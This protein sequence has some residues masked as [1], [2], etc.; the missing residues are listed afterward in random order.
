MPTLFRLSVYKKHT[1]NGGDDSIE[2]TLQHAQTVTEKFTLAKDY[3]L[4]AAMFNSKI[5]KID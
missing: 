5:I 3:D 2:N 1:I 4:S